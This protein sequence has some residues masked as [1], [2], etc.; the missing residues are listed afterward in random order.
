MKE[1][2]EKKVSFGT[3]LK[4][5]FVAAVMS[6][7]SLVP[8]NGNLFLQQ[9]K[10]EEKTEN[11]ETLENKENILNS[12]IKT[13]SQDDVDQIKE[14]V[15]IP[16]IARDPI[17][18]GGTGNSFTFYNDLLG[19]VAE[20]LKKKEI[21]AVVVGATHGGYS[22]KDILEKEIAGYYWDNRGEKTE[23]YGKVRNYDTPF[24]E[25]IST[26]WG[27]LDRTDFDVFFVQNHDEN[28]EYDSSNQQL[29]EKMKNLVPSTGNLVFIRT[30]GELSSDELGEFALENGCSYLDINAF[31]REQYP[32]DWEKVLTREDESKHPTAKMQFI[33]ALFEVGLICGKEALATDIGLYNEPGEQFA[34]VIKSEFKRQGSTEASDSIT[35]EEAHMLQALVYKYF[36]QYVI[37]RVVREDYMKQFE[38][39]SKSSKHENKGK[40]IGAID[41]S[42]F[43]TARDLRSPIVA[44][45]SCNTH[46]VMPNGTRR[47]VPA[48][49][50]IKIIGNMI[51]VNNNGETYSG[52]VA[53]NQQFLRDLKGINISINISN[54]N[55]QGKSV[56]SMEK[57]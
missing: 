26:D 8:R 50:D 15:Q 13:M 5:I 47:N 37:D 51:I 24:D 3:R 28:R 22:L 21:D 9:A 55:P 32:G 17:K 48:F 12:E 1:P 30:T 43:D 4:A 42:I 11:T 19:N 36:D 25:I 2:N 44:T 16:T 10:A 57:D 14:K 29:V 54:E 41:K 18:V 49:T 31:V 53:H 45:T 23:F 38:D 35:K 34:S 7:S 33:T 52:L 20:M 40:K 6:I 56:A 39:S 46:I 27:N